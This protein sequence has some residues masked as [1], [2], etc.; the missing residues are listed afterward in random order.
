[1]PPGGP[2]VVAAEE[3]EEAEEEEAEEEDTMPAALSPTALTADEV[4]VRAGI[5][6]TRLTAVPPMM[7]AF[8]ETGCIGGG[9]WFK[10][11]TFSLALNEIYAK[12]VQ[13]THRN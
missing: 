5:V 3:E 6:G 2:T 9:T 7:L 8:P 11:T 13:Q 1:M 12:N 4:S 10:L